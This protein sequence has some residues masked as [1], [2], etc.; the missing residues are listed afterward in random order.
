MCVCKCVVC[1]VRVSEYATK[2]LFLLP[3][4]FSFFGLPALRVVVIAR[5]SVIY[6]ALE[7]RA[8]RATANRARKQ[9]AALLFVVQI[10][11]DILDEGQILLLCPSYVSRGLKSSLH[12]KR[13]G[14]TR[15]KVRTEIEALSRVVSNRRICQTCIHARVEWIT[16]KEA[17]NALFASDCEL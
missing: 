4:F 12:I 14:G 17:F 3:L 7:R 8:F 16:S 13:H 9:S 15:V 1:G 11:F 6:V 2:I 5:T 10:T